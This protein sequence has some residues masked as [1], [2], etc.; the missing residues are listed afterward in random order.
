LPKALGNA[1]FHILSYGM[2]ALASRSHFYKKNL[3]EPSFS[4][5]EQG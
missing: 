4:T 5:S 1:I 2:S 3:S